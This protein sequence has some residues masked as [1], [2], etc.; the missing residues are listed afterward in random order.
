MNKRERFVMAQ[1]IIERARLYRLLYGLFTEWSQEQ[2]EAFE[3]DTAKSFDRLSKHITVIQ[4]RIQKKLV[5]DCE[6]AL[7]KK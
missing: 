7:K 2:Y 5:E 1:I 4:K 3:R 6:K